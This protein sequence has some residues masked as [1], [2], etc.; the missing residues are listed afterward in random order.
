MVTYFFH[1]NFY[2]KPSKEHHA[3]VERRKRFA[4]PSYRCYIILNQ[5]LTSKIDPVSFS[6]I[7]FH[8]ILV[9]KWQMLTIQYSPPNLDPN[10]RSFPFF[11]YELWNRLIDISGSQHSWYQVKS[12]FPLT[13]SRRTLAFAHESRYVICIVR[14]SQAEIKKR[15]VWDIQ[16]NKNKMLNSTKS[17][18]V[19][20]PGIV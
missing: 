11:R 4:S 7:F 8:S 17:L 15:M 5:C 1:S 10:F 20:D 3:W 6:T 9:Y 2:S 16:G 13:I 14:W 19:I 12:C 18:L